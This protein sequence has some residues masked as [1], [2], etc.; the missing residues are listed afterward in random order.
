M[1]TEQ[2]MYNLILDYAERDPRVR[3]VLLNGSRANPAAPL[4]R[5]RDFDI[6]YLVTDVAP[7]K[8][9]DISSS[10]GEE[11][12]I[13]DRLVDLLLILGNVVRARN[14]GVFKLSS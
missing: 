1:R 8:A 12:C 11:M 2:E 13:R 6:V 3:G 7:Y 5:F 10:F 9:G 4:D 14:D